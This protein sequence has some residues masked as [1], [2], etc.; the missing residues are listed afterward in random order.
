MFGD[1]CHANICMY[2]T[3]ATQQVTG[4]TG[5]VESQTRQMYGTLVTKQGTWKH[6]CNEVIMIAKL[7]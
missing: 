6:R 1:A 5:A 7:A 4:Y 2:K 3:C